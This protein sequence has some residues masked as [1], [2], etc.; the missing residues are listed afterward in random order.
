[1]TWLES[2]GA[3]RTASALVPQANI[4]DPTYP[5]T[6]Q[7]LV[8]LLVGPS[9]HAG[10][11]VTEKSAF[12]LPAVYRAIAVIAST[13]GS[14][15]LHVYRQRGDVRERVPGPHILDQ[16]HPDMTPFEWAE[17]LFVHLLGWG[18]AY[19]WKLRDQAGNVRELWPIE[20]S[21]VQVGRA[22]TGEKVYGVDTSDLGTGVLDPGTGSGSIRDLLPL[23][24][25]EILHIP[26]LGYDGVM[27]M[28]PIRACRQALALA[29]ASEEHGARFFGSGTMLSGV[30]ST[31][32]RIGADTAD[33]LKQRWKQS[34]GGLENAHEVAVL[35]HG[36]KFSPIS[37]SPAD[38]QFIETQR[39]GVQQVARIFGVPPHM[40]MDTEKS[41][42]WGTGIEQQGIGFV[43]YTLRPWL[44]RVEQRMATL[45]P[46]GQYARFSVEGLLRGDTKARFDSYAVGRQ[47]GWLNVNDIR[48]LEDL[49]PVDGGDVYLQPLN[50]VPLGTP[51]APPPA[52]ALEPAPADEPAD[53]AATE[54]A[55]A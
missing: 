47:W 8:D 7:T 25:R 16:P 30:L 52:P 32:Q 31:E 11:S 4:H 15:P 55:D 21:R 27:G 19:L 6:S 22:S 26:G 40:L 1:M 49:P 18:N 42:S 39:F 2:L 43:T 12:G 54:G 28:S 48:S 24:D 23:T 34:N 14:L 10:V 37:V 5:L 36:T 45:Y 20:P 33:E 29:M 13:N 38:A 35:G 3:A 44:T 46:R 17:L 9:T 53:E 51:P 50:M 41:T